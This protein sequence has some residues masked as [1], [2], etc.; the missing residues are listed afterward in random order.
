LIVIVDASDGDA[1]AGRE[2]ATEM[3]QQYAMFLASS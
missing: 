3:P 1:Y 2:V